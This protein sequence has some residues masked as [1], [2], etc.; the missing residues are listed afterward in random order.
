MDAVCLDQMDVFPPLDDVCSEILH[1]ESYFLCGA[2]G[3]LICRLVGWLVGCNQILW[4][5]WKVVHL[6]EWSNG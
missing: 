1:E 4:L 6:D 2:V 3:W 5:S